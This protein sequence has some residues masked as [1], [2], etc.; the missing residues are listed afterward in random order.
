MYVFGAV[1][2]ALLL[3]VVPTFNRLVKLTNMVREVWSGIDVQLKRR[4]TLIPNLVETVKDYVGHERNL[5]SEIADPRSM[6][7]LLVVFFILFPWTS[8]AGGDGW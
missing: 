6:R 7:R 2:L 5:L 1:V 3:W 8:H 4:S